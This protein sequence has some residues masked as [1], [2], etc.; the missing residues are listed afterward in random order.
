MNITTIPAFPSLIHQI[1]LPCFDLIVDSLTKDIL[2]YRDNNPGVQKS[3]I[4]GYQS[5]DKFW[6]TEKFEEY[7]EYIDLNITTAISLVINHEI[8]L[9]NAWFNINYSKDYNFPHTH[10]GSIFSCVLWI[11]IPKNAGP[12]CFHNYTS[13]TANDLVF[14]NLKDNFKQNYNASTEMYFRPEVGKIVI[15]PGYLEHH[16]EPTKDDNDER[17]S[18]A[19]NY[20]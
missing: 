15:F 4:G 14:L 3:N 18:I 8:E 20:S 7:I 6:E 16:V 1:K 10:P 2:E 9:K 19:F 5:D 17:I 12:I 13:K 11:K